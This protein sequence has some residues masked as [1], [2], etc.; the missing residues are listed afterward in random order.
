MKFKIIGATML[1]VTVGAGAAFAAAGLSV[2]QV[3]KFKGVDKDVWSKIGAFCSIKDWHPAVAKCEESKDGDVSFRTLTLKDG[4]VIKEKLT[5]STET[6]YTYAIVESPLPVKDY[7][8]SF[9]AKPDRDEPDTVLVVWS[10]SFAA[11]GKPDSEARTVIEGIFKDGLASIAAKTA[12][13]LAAAD[14]A[15]LPTRKAGLWELKTAMDEGRGPREQLLKMCVGAEMEAST[16]R[17]SLTEHQQNCDT[18][19]IKSVGDETVVDAKCLFNGRHVDSTTVMSGD[20]GKAFK[21]KIDSTTSD[22]KDS[23]EQTVVVKRTIIQTGTFVSDSCGD[24][25]PGEASAPDGE[26][27]TV[28]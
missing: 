15:T 3:Q 9:S 22:K 20:F 21:V 10:A 6:G 1:A 19:D 13:N 2:R 23:T 16:V 4:G 25:K 8:A 26:K 17:A 24:L 18:Y 27:V 11:K 28:Q 12:A 7:F 14:A 5:G